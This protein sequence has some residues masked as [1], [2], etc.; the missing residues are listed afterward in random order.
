MAPTWSINGPFMVPNGPS[1]V[2]ANHNHKINFPSVSLLQILG[3][4]DQGEMFGIPTEWKGK[5]NTFA[6]F[7]SVLVSALSV[8]SL[9]HIEIISFIIIEDII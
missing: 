1:K 3:P 9:E 5:G 6:T 2:L 4:D 8:I 7:S